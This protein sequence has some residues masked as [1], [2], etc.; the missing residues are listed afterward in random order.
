MSEKSL[1]WCGL[2]CLEG[3]ISRKRERSLYRSSSKK[4]L[5]IEVPKI[6]KLG[7]SKYAICSISPRGHGDVLWALRLCLKEIH[8]NLVPIIRELWLV[9]TRML[10][11]E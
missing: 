5:S 2:L 1:R 9:Q 7:G 6:G 4:E 10:H 11:I 3:V 8:I